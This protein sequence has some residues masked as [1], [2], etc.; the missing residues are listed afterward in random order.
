MCVQAY[1]HKE[2]PNGLTIMT[3]KS[4]NLFFFFC[5]I[6]LSL[7]TKFQESKK[8]TFEIQK[9]DGFRLFFF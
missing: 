1:T 6:D 7:S 5:N 2:R 3:D 4:F 8:G 9:I